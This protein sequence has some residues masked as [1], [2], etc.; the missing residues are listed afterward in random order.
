MGVLSSKHFTLAEFLPEGQDES[1]VPGEVVSNIEALVTNLL[2][3]IREFFGAPV[4]IH[5][6]WRPPEKNAEVGGVPTSDH[7]RGAAADFRVASTYDSTW[8]ENTIAAFDWLRMNKSLDFGQLILE[9]H[10]AHYGLT[11]KLWVHVS[12]RSAKHDGTKNDPNRLLVSYAPKKYALW[13]DAGLA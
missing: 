8:E 3:P 7:Q 9:D 4:V 10:R 2:G 1:T 11:G 13:A 5:S 12:L 6:G